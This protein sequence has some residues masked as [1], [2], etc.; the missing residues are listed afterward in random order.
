MENVLVVRTEDVR[1]IIKAK[2]LITEHNAELLEIIREKG[3]ALPRPQAEE[4]AA[5]KQI[6]P[7]VVI[8]RGGEV[9]STRRLKKGAEARLHGLISL[10]VGGHIEPSED[11]EGDM[12]QNGLHREIAEEVYIERMAEPQLRGAINDDTNGVGSV[13]LGLL[14]TL[15][16]DGEVSVRETEKLEGAWLKRDELEAVRERMETWSQIAMEIL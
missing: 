15:D 8:R 10:G 1:H 13:H 16:T 11:G 4:D 3:F 6:I 5:Y 2:G 14:Y 12:L 9:F 7:Y